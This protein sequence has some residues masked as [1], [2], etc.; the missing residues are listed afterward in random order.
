MILLALGLFIFLGLHSTRIVSEDGRARAIAWIGE[1]RWKG[2]YSLVSLVGFVLI[3]WGFGLA[4]YDAA[5]LW[6]PPSGARH[7]TLL[8]MLISIVLLAGYFFKTSHI[9]TALHHPMLWAVLVWSVAHLSANGSAAD[10]LLFGAFLVWSAADLLNSYA[11][12]R[13][14]AVVYPTPSIAATLGAVIVGVALYAL[15]VGGLHAWLFGVSPF[16]F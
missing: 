13:Q 8:L 15:L 6:S 2:L 14:N 11:R 12:D 5:T 10:V 3:I 9:S 4:R 7:L 16:A 1:G